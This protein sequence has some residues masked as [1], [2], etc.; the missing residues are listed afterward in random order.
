METK[1]LEL[2]QDEINVLLLAI[3]NQAE[4]EQALI[5]IHKTH[6][7]LMVFLIMLKKKLYVVL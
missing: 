2:S 7:N 5:K 1:T 3:I 4:T 6:V